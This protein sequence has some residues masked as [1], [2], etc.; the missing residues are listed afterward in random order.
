[1]TAEHPLIS[2]VVARLS[3]PAINLAA[4]GIVFAICIV[5]Q[6]PST[7]LLAASLLVTGLALGGWG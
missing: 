7:M 5:I 3:E 1:M 4:W 6:S 2:A